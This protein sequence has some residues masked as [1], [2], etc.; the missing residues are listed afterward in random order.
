MKLAA[1]RPGVYS[2]TLTSHELSALLAG[3]RMSLSL[4]ETDPAGATAEA[5]AALGSVLDD[6]DRELAKTRE[7]GGEPDQP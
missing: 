3:A 6:F 2:V 7:S 4:M 1:D 5:R